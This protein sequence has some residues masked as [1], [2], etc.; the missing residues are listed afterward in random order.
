MQTILILTK[1]LMVQSSVSAVGRAEGLKIRACRSASR[2][3]ERMVEEESVAGIFIDLQ[4]PDL[5][6][7]ELADVL[8]PEDAS[9]S[10]AFAQHVEEQL[11]ADANMPCIGKVLTRGQF[12]RGLAE[13]VADL[14]ESDG[15]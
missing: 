11:L 12:S 1:D 7:Q 10:I 3:A 2:L 15:R 9:R 13:L 4:T 14:L 6:M 5:S 8:S